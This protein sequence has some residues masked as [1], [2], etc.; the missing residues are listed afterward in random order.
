MRDPWEVLGVQRG[1]A[2][3][4]IKRIY[5]ELRSKLHPDRAGGDQ[6]LFN[7]V[8]QAWE[9]LN[10]PE[11]LDLYERTGSADQPPPVEQKATTHLM[12]IFLNLARGNNYQ[13]AFYV[14]TMRQT[15]AA[16]I[17]SG[18]QH[19]VEA[20]AVLAR[21]RRAAPKGPDGGNIFANVIDQEADNLD[22]TIA[23]I[24]GR[25]ELLEAAQ[26]ILEAYDD[27]AP[28]DPMSG[29]LTFSTN[30]ATGSF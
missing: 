25:L 21:I 27:D 6:E 14:K 3:D 29:A 11:R 13:P 10:D 8:Q 5:Q 17:V 20:S 26:V 7:E 9:L 4:R 12:S 28:V 23:E 22:T 15:L 24:D 2:H 1:V 16:D 30:S 19:R 18:N